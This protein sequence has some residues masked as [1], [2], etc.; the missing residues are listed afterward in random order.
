MTPEKIKHLEFI[1]NIITRMNTN[2]FQLK[3]MTITIMAAL[4]A[5]YASTSNIKF[6]LIISLPVILFWFLN[7]YYLQ[8]ERKFRGIYDDVSG[9]TQQYVI[10]DFEMPLNKYTRGNYRYYKSLFS[11][12]LK[13]F[14]GSIL[15]IVLIGLIIMVFNTCN[16]TIECK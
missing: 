9:V 1:Q 16:I 7:A 14:Y 12:T 8:M 2:S 4:L 13:S 11:P 6:L 5:V 3:G 10:K 15:V